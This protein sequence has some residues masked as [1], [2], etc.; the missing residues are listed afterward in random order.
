MNTESNTIP[1][2]YLNH[3]TGLWSWL[4][5]KDHKRIGLLYLY[6]ITVFFLTAAVLGLLMRIEKIAPG[7][8]IM[9]AQTYNA[10]FTIHGIIMIFVIVIPGLSA[11]FG[12]FF[13]PI[14]LGAKD[15]A[16]PRLNLFAWYLYIAGAAIALYSQFAY[17]HSPDAGWTFYVP[18]SAISQ[19]NMVLALFG[20]FV[21]G[22][23][24]ILT[25]LNFIVTIHRL[26]A[27]GMTWFKMP[28][29][30]WAI[31]A[32][33]WIQLLATPIIGITLLMVI[34]E[35]VLQIG[36]FNPA[37]G[38][39][40]LLY[41]HLFWIYS[42]PAVYIMILPAMGVVTEI[43]PTF[44]QKPVFGYTAIAMSS[45]AIAFIGYFVWGHHMFTSGI[46]FY[47][48][49]FFSLLTFLVAIPSA[50]KVFNWLGTLYGGSID[51]KPP[52]LYALAFIFLFMIG[53][54]S[55]LA[56]G[57]LA[58]NV[59]L[60]DTDFI[61]AHFHYIVFGGM[62]FGFFAAVHYWYPKIYGKMYNFRW[63]NI[64]WAFLFIGFNTLYFPMFILGIEGMPRRYFDYL[65]RFQPLQVISTIGAFILITGVIVMLSNLIYHYYRGAAA[66]ANPWHGVTLEWKIPSP[67]PEENFETEP[68]IT[69]SPYLFEHPETN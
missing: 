36:F 37:L 35:R 38:G 24:S 34:A 16:F 47:S 5:T 26:R 23:A 69:H 45:L 20:A 3:K 62:G 67:P 12:N 68:V 60:T 52:L 64:G 21:L 27:P 59:H 46:G 58:A 10:M 48:R 53:G 15:V 28:L 50:I 44:S 61:V 66:P 57:A 30:P 17:G 39:D 42:H 22:F 40:P 33:A 56:Q 7:A 29:F 2:N 14:M 55:G 41:Q 6:A 51:L 4:T 18:Y 63:A 65:P 11:V 25:G 9:T 54:F 19:S 31:Y 32:T 49:V 13:L 8:T 1:L 43:F